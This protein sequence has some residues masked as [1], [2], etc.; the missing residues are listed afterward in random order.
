MWIP[1]RRQ[2]LGVSAQGLAAL[3]LRGATDDKT[4]VALVA[5]T[6]SKLI[7][8][9]SLEDPLDYPRI[10]NMVWQAIE[11]GRPRAGSLEDKIKPGSWVVIKPNIIGLP[12]RRTYRT[13]DVTDLRVTKAVLEYVASKSRAA[14]IT[15]AEGGSYRGLHDPVEDNRMIQ[16]GVHVNALT[17]DWST[18]FVG[19]NQTLGEILDEVRGRFPDKKFDYIDLAYDAPKNA[20]GEFDWRDVPLSPN[21]VGAFGAKKQYVMAKTI[22]DC[23]FLISVPVMKVHLVCGLTGCLKN[24]VGTAPRIVYTTPGSFSNFQLHRDCS[25]EGRFDP[26]IVDLAAFHPPDYCVVDAIRGLQYS[27]HGTNRDDQQ[28]RS[29]MILAGEDPV[30][31][32]S[33][34]ARL[35]GYQPWDIQFLHMA[36]QRQIGTMDAGKIDVIGDDPDRLQRRWGKPNNWTG[37]CN[38]EWLVTQNPDAK[39]ESW[40]RFTSPAD[41][42]HLAEWQEPASDTTTY[43]SAVRVISDGAR[44]AF[45]WMG[46]H[47]E[48]TAYLNGDKVMQEKGVTRYRIG[49]FQY[50]VELRSGENLLVVETKP[51]RGTADVSV[52]LVGPRNDG[53]SAEGFRWTA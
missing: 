3:T 14:R 33:M 20:A 5:S 17:A 11:Y 45:L 25:V 52:L 43:R 34:L 16:N 29:N 46:V 36:S 37:R 40:T 51:F 2:F 19:F 4:R 50:P 44:K 28:M 27:E 26:F 49:Q 24:Y 10:R 38:R 47:G 42:L 15:V 41:T 39:I 1:S 13:G 6:H 8:P 32:D 53:D 18:E 21:G 48:V 23:D 31:T 35:M 30:A 9:S 22:L 7:Q 12:P